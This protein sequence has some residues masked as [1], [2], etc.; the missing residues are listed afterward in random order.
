MLKM[1][2]QVSYIKNETIYLF[3][4]AKQRFQL[5]KILGKFMLFMKIS[6]RLSG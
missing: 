1:P 5:Q 2:D 3:V 4:L 6:W